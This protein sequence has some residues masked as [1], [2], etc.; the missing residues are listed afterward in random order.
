[1]TQSYNRFLK[2]LFP[3]VGLVFL[4]ACENPYIVQFKEEFGWTE[5]RAVKDGWLESRKIAPPDIWCYETIGQADCFEKPD[6][7][8]G[9][10]LV[11]KFHLQ[12]DF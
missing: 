1:M 4:S 9:S 10:R 3:F 8:E 2:V 5:E 11:E 12:P 6:E 7:T